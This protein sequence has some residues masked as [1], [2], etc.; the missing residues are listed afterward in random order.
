MNRRGA[1]LAD[2]EEGP[3]DS[4]KECAAREQ[5]AE[6]DKRDG[7]CGS[8]LQAVRRAPKLNTMDGE[9]VAEID[10]VGNAGEEGGPRHFDPRERQRRTDGADEREHG[11]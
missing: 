4:E 7:G 10:A 9:F 5:N 6:K 8:E 2:L 11:R 1:A 3:L